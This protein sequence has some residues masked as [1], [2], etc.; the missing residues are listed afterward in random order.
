M[1]KTKASGVNSFSRK[2]T[3]ALCAAAFIAFALPSLAQQKIA[4]HHVRA[5]VQNGQTKLQSHLPA[6]Q[7]LKLAIAL[8]LRNQTDL[9]ELLQ[10]L[11]DPTSSSY[12]HWLSVQEF[13]DQFGPTEEDYETVARFAR[14]NGMTVTA[15]SP[16]RMVIDVKGSVADIEKTFHV[17][18]G[19]YK[20][21][22]EDRT[23]YA[24]DREP[25]TDLAVQ[26]WHITGLDDFSL[27]KPHLRFAQPADVHTFTTGSGPGG[28]FLG[29]DIRAAYYGGTALTGAGQTIGLYGLDYNLSDVELYYSS[30][31]QSFSAS[32]V[33]NYSTD[34]TTNSCSGCDD[35]EPVID[36]YESLSMAPSATIIEYFGNSDVDTFNAMASANVAKQL[37]ASVGWLP[38]D[39]SSDE[40]IFKEFAAQGQNL[41][42]ASDDSGAY[43]S[44]TPVYYPADDPYI[45]AAGWV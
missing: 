41:F 8:P 14:A 3:T 17:T 20:H 4:T 26:L 45:T 36:I 7:T 24:A 22:T 2:L 30:I 31:G 35:G 16:N 12:H 40:P 21:P 43:S 39:P 27:P 19:V 9:D 13:T 5:V 38:A 15:T 34:G 42:A 25:T 6:T 29:S 11:Y 32:S 18:M 1:K 33:Q 44:T 37:S 23:F 28:T 10:K